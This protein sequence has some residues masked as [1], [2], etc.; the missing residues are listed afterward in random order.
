MEIDKFN[1]MVED[2]KK[3]NLKASYYICF[4]GDTAY[5][6]NTNNIIANSVVE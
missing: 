1:A 4:F 5:F 3:K 2:K 6:Y